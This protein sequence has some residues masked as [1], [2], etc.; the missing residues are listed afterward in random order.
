MEIRGLLEKKKELLEEQSQTTTQ[1]G[2]RCTIPP[3]ELEN[4]ISV[5]TNAEFINKA[6]YEKES[7]KQ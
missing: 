3:E 1:S 7:L 4:R 5:S 2:I 6:L